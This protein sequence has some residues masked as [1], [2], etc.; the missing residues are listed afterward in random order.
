VSL[1]ENIYEIVRK[2]PPGNVTSYGKIATIV[3]CGARQVGYAMAAT[4]SGQGI[5]WHRVINSKGEIS[6]R[7]EGSGDSNQ[8]RLLIAEGI[9]FDRHGRVS[10]DDYGWIEAELPFWPEEIPGD[11]EI[12]EH[13]RDEW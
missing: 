9:V 1:Y 5:P 12:R 2:I 4:P 11:E 8:K 3:N 13:S 7:K 10:F 6:A